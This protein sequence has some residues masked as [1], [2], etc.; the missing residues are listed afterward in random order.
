MGDV[1]TTVYR[2]LPNRD[3]D[4]VAQHYVQHLPVMFNAWTSA[5]TLVENARN[6][7]GSYGVILKIT[8]FSGKNISHISMFEFENEILLTPRHRFVVS[9]GIY[10]DGDYS[11]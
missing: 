10:Q 8:V 1:Q 9:R 3:R 7:A 2:G 11:Y 6:F 5:S 4:F